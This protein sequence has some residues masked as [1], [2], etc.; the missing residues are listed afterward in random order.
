MDASCE[1]KRG[2]VSGR[3]QPSRLYG[4]ADLTL[5]TPLHGLPNTSS[6]FVSRSTSRREPSRCHTTRCWSFSLTSTL[7][8]QSHT[9]Q[10]QQQQQQQQTPTEHTVPNHFNAMHGRGEGSPL[11]AVCGVAVCGAQHSDG[12]LGQV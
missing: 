6:T 8:T 11:A 4:L 3:T 7:Q 1:G 5:N 2:G 9:P 12:L 10:Q